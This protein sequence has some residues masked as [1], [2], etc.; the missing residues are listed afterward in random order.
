MTT[1]AQ[2][3]AATSTVL[4]GG[5]EYH[6][7]PLTDRD[8]A[9]LDLWHQ[10]RTIRMARASLNDEATEEERQFTMAA[11]FRFAQGLSFMGD[12]LANSPLKTPPIL[13]MDGLSQFVWRMI[14]RDQ[15]RLAPDDVRSLLEAYPEATEA[16]MDVFLLMVGVTKKK[17]SP[18]PGPN[19]PTAATSTGA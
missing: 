12:S 5:E 4:I 16:I 8:W 2:A 18:G 1:P 3:T 13:S 10:G 6:L 17:D 11:A 9:E 19:S 15:P 7:R 14:R